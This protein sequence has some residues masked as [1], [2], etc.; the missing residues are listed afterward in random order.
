MQSRYNAIST[1]RMGTKPMRTASRLR[2]LW[3]QGK[4]FFIPLL[5]LLGLTGL[6]GSVVGYV[7]WD[8]RRT[9]EVKCLAETVDFYLSFTAHDKVGAARV[10]AERQTEAAARI[11]IAEAAKMNQR[12]C[13]TKRWKEVR[14]NILS[15]VW[16][17]NENSARWKFIYP[18]VF[19]AYMA[20]GPLGLAGVYRYKYEWPK[21][22]ECARDYKA[23]ALRPP[24]LLRPDRSLSE[25]G[26]IGT[27]I[28]LC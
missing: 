18:I 16:A 25:A 11:H 7:M 13:A 17:S 15:A 4:M 14:D 26:N 27:F 23:T 6:M 20:S 24:V 2:L 28:V 9:N 21:A 8:D 12:L 22:W 3:R 19:N 5:L 10:L 1:N